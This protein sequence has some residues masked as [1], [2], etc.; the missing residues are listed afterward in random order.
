[1]VVGIKSGKAGEVLLTE[2]ILAG[3]FLTVWTGNYFCGKLSRHPFGCV[4]IRKIC[5]GVL[6]VLILAETGR[7][8]VSAER[9][10]HVFFHQYR[11][12]VE[13]CEEHGV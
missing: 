2:G 7:N 13:F 8:T 6:A 9:D 4:E 10:V 5:G 12:N 11:G 1:M 3:M